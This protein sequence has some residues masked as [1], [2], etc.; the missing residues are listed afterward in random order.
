M[1][2]S[3][4]ALLAEPRR[5]AAIEQARQAVLVGRS[6]QSAVGL[7]PGIE[8]S[9]RRCLDL[10]HEPERAVTFNAISA[11]GARRV[12]DASRPLLQAATPVVRTLTRAM[13]HT[14]YFRHP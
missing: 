9:W 3:S 5:L 10:G 14:R 2:S 11:Q 13:L 1:T 7:S 4:P 8:R 6:A 12:L